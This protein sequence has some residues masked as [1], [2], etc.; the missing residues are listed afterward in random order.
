MPMVYEI[1]WIAREPKTAPGE[2]PRCRVFEMD[3]PAGLAR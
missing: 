1:D 2:S 3:L